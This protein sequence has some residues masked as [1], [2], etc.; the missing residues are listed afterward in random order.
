MVALGLVTHTALYPVLLLPPLL[1]ILNQG[2]KAL[3]T[4]VSDAMVFVQVYATAASV[5]TYLLGMS[6]STATLGVMCVVPKNVLTPACQRQTSRQT[7][8]CGGTF[9]TKCLTISDLSSA[10][11]SRYA[12]CER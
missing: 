11:S 9:S 7:S 1:L 5:F 12:I 3:W 2:N 6:W 10:V 4:R 8:A